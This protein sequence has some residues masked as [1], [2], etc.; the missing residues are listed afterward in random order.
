MN[1]IQ[2]P[3]SRDIFTLDGKF[4]CPGV[5]KIK[6]GGNQHVTVQD[7]GQPLTTGKNTLVRSV[8]NIV[9]TYEIRLWTLA[10]FAAWDTFEAM[11][12]EG[13]AR[14][15]TPRSYVF[16]DLRI[17]RLTKV[18]V[19]DIGPEM[20]IARGGP[21]AHDVT[22]HQWSRV[23]QAGGAVRPPATAAQIEIASLTADNGALNNQLA[24][25][26]AA[27]RAGT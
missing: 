3:A 14:Y 9:V 16:G 23:K 17:P 5:A 15:P 24:A 8:E 10:D 1:P 26:Q 21:W 7:M 19:E 25:A 13:K 11:L 2:N 18:I 12:A 4:T 27:A 20:V 22:F 6:S